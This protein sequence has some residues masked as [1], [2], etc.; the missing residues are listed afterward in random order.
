MYLYWLEFGS[1][2]LGKPDLCET[3]KYYWNF[4]AVVASVVFQD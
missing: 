4:M 2:Q 3:G 1:V